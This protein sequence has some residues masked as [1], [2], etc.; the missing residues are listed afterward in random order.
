MDVIA[1]SSCDLLV[2]IGLKNY[3]YLGAQ[4][5]PAMLRAD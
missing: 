4:E 1:T 2:A 3:L 5:Y